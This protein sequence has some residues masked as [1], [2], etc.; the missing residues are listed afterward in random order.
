MA[1]PGNDG[2][3]SRRQKR[4]DRSSGPS[5][6]EAKTTLISE[7]SLSFSRLSKKTSEKS[8]FLCAFPDSPM[9][10][11]PWTLGLWFSY[12]QAELCFQKLLYTKVATSPSF[13]TQMVSTPTI[14]IL[15]LMTEC[16]RSGGC[17]LRF[18]IIMST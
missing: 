5:H 18:Q 2:G 13:P 15:G 11:W 10:L 1:G 14:S 3:Q 12:R 7:S 17:T 4:G 8:K 6:Q 16:G 9:I